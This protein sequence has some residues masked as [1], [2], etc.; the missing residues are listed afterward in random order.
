MNKK[1]KITEKSIIKELKHLNKI[2][3]DMQEEKNEGKNR[4]W[5]GE[6]IDDVIDRVKRRIQYIERNNVREIKVKKVKKDLKK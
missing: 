4:C 6:L 1:R 2:L 3:D 5:T